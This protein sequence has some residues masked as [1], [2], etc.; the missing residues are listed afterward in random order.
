MNSNQQSNQH[1]NTGLLIVVAAIGIAIYTFW[2]AILNFIS[3]ALSL[4]FGIFVLVLYIGGAI[5][6]YNRKPSPKRA[7]NCDVDLTDLEKLDF[8]NETPK[9]SEPKVRHVPR[10]IEEPEE[11]IID[12]ITLFST[13]LHNTNNLIAEEQ[14]LLERN[15][16]Q[17]KEFV[18]LGKMR[19]ETFLI[20]EQKPEGLTHTFVVHSIVRKLKRITKNIQTYATLNP[21]IVF[22]YKGKTYALE[23]ET[24]LFL[25][26]K[27]KRLLAKAQANNETYGKNWWIVV[28][29]SAYARS[30]RRYGKVLRRNDIDQ[31]IKQFRKD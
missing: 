1:D 31:W 8:E 28:T 23:I 13:P 30:F 25:K 12:T 26:K 2:T 10:P 22:K 17:K 16:Y 27:H 6:I 14:S 24:P 19:R 4:I 3:V 21:D 11:V 7:T 29:T 18:P 15:G 9:R 5:C 20:K